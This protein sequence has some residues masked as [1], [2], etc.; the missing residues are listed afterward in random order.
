MKEFIV[1]RHDTILDILI[2]VGEAS[3]KSEARMLVR[4]SYPIFID[5]K[6][7]YYEDYE[8]DFIHRNKTDKKYHKMNNVVLLKQHSI[9]RI[10]GS[11]NPHD[12]S[13]G[14]LYKLIRN[15]SVK[16]EFLFY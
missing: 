16:G 4:S 8:I 12:Y 6:R 3:S 5:D 7:V 13:G 14:R 11:W 10:G 9:M 15:G 2:R 1:N